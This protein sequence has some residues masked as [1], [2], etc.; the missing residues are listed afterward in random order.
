M[1]LATYEGDSIKAINKKGDPRRASLRENVAVPLPAELNLPWQRRH[2]TS[3]VTEEINQS[4]F[5]S[6]F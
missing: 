6:R 3:A 5:L 2:P 4:A 1:R